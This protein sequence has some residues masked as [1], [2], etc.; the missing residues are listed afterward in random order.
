MAIDYQQIVATVDELI[1]Q[2]GRAITLM[3][4]PRTAADADKPWNGPAEWNDASPPAGHSIGVSAVFVGEAAKFSGNRPAFAADEADSLI[5]R[6]SSGYLVSGSV[7]ADLREFD[8]I[9]DGG[10]LWKINAVNVLQ[11]GATVLL[12]G[13][14]VSQ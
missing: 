13:L 4:T 7:N 10:Q 9:D 1:P 3:K 11:P 12:Y 6:G 14:E 5:R 2:F 8:R